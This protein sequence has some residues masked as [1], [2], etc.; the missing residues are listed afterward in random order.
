MTEYFPLYGCD[1]ELILVRPLLKASNV[2]VQ[3][4]PHTDETSFPA[5]VCFWTPPTTSVECIQ[6][7]SKF[8]KKSLVAGIKTRPHSNKGIYLVLSSRDL[9]SWDI[10][11]VAARIS[12]PAD[13][14]GVCECVCVLRH[15]YGRAGVTVSRISTIRSRKLNARVLN[16]NITCLDYKVKCLSLT[17]LRLQSKMSEHVLD[18]GHHILMPIL[19]SLKQSAITHQNPVTDAGNSS[20]RHLHY[21][22]SKG[23]NSIYSET[24][25]RV[26]EPNN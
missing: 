4:A 22:L 26:T 21:L 17:V 14:V 16:P 19:F 8:E 13:N 12:F 10:V 7:Q 11:Y 9:E 18:S 6:M 1:A 24:G 3:Y 25:V 20:M 15:F 23:T 5:A 2:R